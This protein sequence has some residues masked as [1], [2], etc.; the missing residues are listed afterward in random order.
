MSAC[1]F[2]VASHVCGRSK[3]RLA[4]WNRSHAVKCIQIPHKPQTV[5]EA[6]E[7][8]AALPHAWHSVPISMRKAQRAA[9]RSATFSNATQRP[10]TEGPSIRLASEPS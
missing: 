9:I 3:V 6:R 2:A 7:P 1:S 8:H 4:D 10:A 5:H